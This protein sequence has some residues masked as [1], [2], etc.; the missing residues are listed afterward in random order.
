MSVDDLT[1]GS[2]GDLSRER[3]FVDRMERV[4]RWSFAGSVA[5]AGCG[6]VAL[7]SFSSEIPGLAGGL[8]VFFG[9]FIAWG[10]ALFLRLLPDA[11]E[12]LN[13]QPVDMMFERRYQLSRVEAWRARLWA[14]D[15]QDR[16][17]AWFGSVQWATPLLMTAHKVGAKVYGTPKLGSAVV[18][19]CSQGLL[20]GRITVSHVDEDLV[21]GVPPRGLGWLFRPIRLPFSRH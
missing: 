7:T 6:V 17:L 16:P 4:T 14:T 19:S 18:V 12:A 20:V 15:A 2:L 5:L 13:T 21:A 11:R 9:V 8:A 1:A 10:Y 3:A